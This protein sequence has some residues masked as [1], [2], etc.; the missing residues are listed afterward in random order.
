MPIPLKRVINKALNVIPSERYKCAEEMRHAIEQVDLCINWTE[1]ILPNGIRWRTSHNKQVIQLL[2]TENKDKTWN[3]ELK[4]GASKSSLRRKSN[5]CK[6]KITKKE[7]DK[8]AK[9]ILQ[10]F[11]LGNEK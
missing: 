10:D 3:I 6:S 8:I 1:N 11:V 5:L 7:A 9:R 2:K 4:K